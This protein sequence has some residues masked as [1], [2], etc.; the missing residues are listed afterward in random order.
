MIKIFCAICGEKEKTKVLYR[1]N[2]NPINLT[3]QI[4]S[5]RRIP[6]NIHY[7]I[8]KCLNCGLIFSS[9]IL[10]EEKI[11]KL[12]KKSKFSYKEQVPYLN[13]TYLYYLKKFL[14]KNFLFLKL[15]DI[16]CGNGFFLEEIYKMGIKNVYGI[17]PSEEA[18]LK[19]SINIKNKIKTDVLKKNIFPDNFFNVITCF[20]TLDHV[21]NP[22]KFLTVVFSLLKKNGMAFF[23]LHDTDG[24][25]VK[26]FKEKSPIFD[27]EHIY[28]FNKET[29]KRIFRMNGFRDIEIFKV[30]N[31]YP[32]LYWVKMVPL[33]ILFKKILTLFLEK[34][35]LGRLVISLN[36]GNIG[37]IAYK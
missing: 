23:V 34:S 30:K 37:L 17:E 19:A 33:P 27:I 4:F 20:Q 14:T 31:K 32:L 12:Y 28:L 21:V 16:G 1:A 24:L 8:N 15:L 6:D 18:S 22:N 5:A 9:P 26:I 25:S 29:L 10:P 11:K 13:Q 35:K 7:Q 2:F 36:A 3:S